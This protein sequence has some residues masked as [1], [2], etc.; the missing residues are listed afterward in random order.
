[1]WSCSEALNVIIYVGSV[2]FKDKLP[3]KLISSSTIS[4]F[5][6]FTLFVLQKTLTNTYGTEMRRRRNKNCCV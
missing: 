4:H 5:L 2:S 6:L 1:M 3:K